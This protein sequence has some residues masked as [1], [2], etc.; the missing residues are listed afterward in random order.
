MNRSETYFTNAWPSDVQL[1]RLLWLGTPGI[2]F[3]NLAQFLRF[4]SWCH[5]SLLRS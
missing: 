3:M 2:V 4:D 1:P 5:T